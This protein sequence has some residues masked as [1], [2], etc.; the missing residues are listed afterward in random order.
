MKKLLSYSLLAL[1]LGAQPLMHAEDIKSKELPESAKAEL[2][3]KGLQALTGSVLCGIYAYGN[4]HQLPCAFD[5]W[6]TR[7]LTLHVDLLQGFKDTIN[8]GITPSEGGRVLLSA[9]GS[10]HLAIYGALC[11]LK[12]EFVTE[13]H[14]KFAIK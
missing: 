8:L 3:K 9:L 4:K 1:A 13:M 10:V 5:N 14:A 2:R 6:K 12:P 11:F 7:N